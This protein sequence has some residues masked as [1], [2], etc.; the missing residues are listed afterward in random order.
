MND[1]HK[2][3]RRKINIGSDY[4]LAL[5]VG[6][7][8]VFLSE[9]PKLF[10]NEAFAL[11]L[12]IFLSLIVAISGFIIVAFSGYEHKNAD[13][14]ESY[15]KPFENDKW[16]EMRSQNKNAKAKKTAKRKKSKA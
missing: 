13:V 7:L 5:M 8:I 4:G 10:G 6:G 9:T 12:T 2:K 3:E 11:G 15:E 1:I 14:M 16:R